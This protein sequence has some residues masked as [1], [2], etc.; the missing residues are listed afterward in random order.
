M[1]LANAGFRLMQP[2]LARSS[3]ERAHDLT[4]AALRLLPVS[5][6]TVADERLESEWFGIR[7]PNPVGLAAG[8]DKNGAVVDQL[9][10]LGF[11]FVE[12]GT[13]TPRLQD[14]NDKPRLFRLEEDDAVIN[15]MGF[16]NLG[17]EAMYRSLMNRSRPGTVGVNI[18]ANKISVDRFAD[19][20][21]GISRFA[22]AADYVTINISS[23]NTPGLRNM[24]A[25]DDLTRLLELARG[26][27]AKMSRQTPLLVKLAPDL[28]FEEL[29]DA[30]EVC[31]GRVEGVIISNTTLNRPPLRSIHGQETGGLSGRPLFD[32]STIQLA[33]FYV[34]TQG[35]IPLVGVGGVCD[36]VT[37]WTKICAGASLVQLYTAL[38]YAG[39]KLVG[40][41]VDG[42]SGMVS[43][44]GLK[45]YRDAIGSHARDIAEGRF[46]GVPHH[47]KGAGT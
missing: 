45:H 8:F 31:L 38:V 42:L 6:A 44:N 19:Y 43:E 29:S 46:P 39:P 11:G 33:R 1:R 28:T 17:H 24:Q 12:V 23:P 34:L 41:I 27:L 10:S 32:L 25:K 14:G 13:T 36:A 21:E 18:G 26:T 4:L 40:T 22:A 15:R 35:R 3:P 16:N 5:S 30:A 7:F 37:A 20:A 9:L 2:L 47:H